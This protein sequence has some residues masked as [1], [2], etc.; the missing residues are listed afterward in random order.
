M[1]KHNR[2]KAGKTSYKHNS[3]T[4]KAYNNH[5]KEHEIFLQKNISNEKIEIQSSLKC[6]DPMTILFFKLDA[7]SLRLWYL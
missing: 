6:G 4:Q 2:N 7:Y 1:S 3:K 5:Q